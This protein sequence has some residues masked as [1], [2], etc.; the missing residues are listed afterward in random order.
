MDAREFTGLAVYP[1]KSWSYPSKMTDFRWFSLSGRNIPH[2]LH[3]SDPEKKQKPPY[4]FQDQP[5][6]PG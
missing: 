5:L 1:F 2:P 3:V 6:N 4:L